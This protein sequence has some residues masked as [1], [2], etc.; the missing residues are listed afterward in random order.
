M[1]KHKELHTLPVPILDQKL[2]QET[3]RKGFEKYPERKK[4][5]LRYK[6]NLD[7]KRVLDYLPFQMDIEPTSRCNYS[8]NMCQV[9][10]WKSSKRADDLS[11]ENYKRI[12][13]TIPTLIEIKIQGMGEPFLNKDFFRMIEYS[14]QEYQWVRS[15]TNASLLHVDDNYKKVVD[16]DIC[17]LQVSI[18]GVTKETYE[19]IRKGGNFSRVMK[20]C[21]LLNSYA[22]YAH[23][24][25]TKAWVLLQKSNFSDLEMFPRILSDLGFDRAVFALTL[26]HWGIRFW[27]D[28]NSKETIFDQFDISMA[29]HLIELGKKYGIEI[30]F[31][32]CDKKY[33]AIYYSNLCQMPFQRI[34]V[35]SD[36]KLV[37]CGMVG[38]PETFCLGNADKI[39]E[40]WNGNK[41]TSFREAHIKGSVPNICKSC[42]VEDNN[43]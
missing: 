28:K 34:Y 12:I 37:P 25:R 13:D 18:D 22:D 21:I 2:W 41:F 7:K 31:W 20:N 16:A 30:T 42:Y 10:Q 32:L 19:S 11:F 36:L 40:E 33:N 1:D 3:L 9:S 29:N 26:N 8:C 27:K 5:Y 38:N 35:S 14:R 6:K 17:E 23:K 15:S 39:I 24:K 4:N 43:E